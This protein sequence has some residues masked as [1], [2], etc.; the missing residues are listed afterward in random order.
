MEPRLASRRVAPPRAV[1]GSAP[2]VL[3]LAFALL[4]VAL[5]VVWRDTRSDGAPTPHPAP[6][7]LA[8]TPDVVR[9][10]ALEPGRRWELAVAD[11]P[12]KRRVLEVAPW[13][14]ETSPPST[15]G[16]LVERGA[17]LLRLS[18]VKDDERKDVLFARADDPPRVWLLGLDVDETPAPLWF[19]P[20]VPF[21]GPDTRVDGVAHRTPVTTSGRVA[22]DAGLFDTQVDV[23][24]AGVVSVR[25]TAEAA[26]RVRL[27]LGVELEAEAQIAGLPV[28][29]T[30]DDSL[31]G[32]LV[33]DRGW[34]ELSDPK[35]TYVAVEPR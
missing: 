20:P 1:A 4:V 6:P 21:A 5:L 15:V 13:T 12:N 14:G 18:V 2:A 17:A 11:R 33:Q 24:A 27:E 22:I 34:V 25:W 26:D 16:V 7:H 10:L 3:V 31:A 9:C 23:T 29:R 32:L 28:T 30:L 19:A 35:R 8:A